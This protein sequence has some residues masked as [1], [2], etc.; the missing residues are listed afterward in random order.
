MPEPETFLIAKNLSKRFGATQVLRDVSLTIRAG[1]RVA[2]T[3]PSGAGKSTLLNCLGGIERPDSGEIRL[4]GVDLSAASPEEL[5]T[6]RRTRI[7][8][9][10]QFFHL[11]PTLTAAENIELPLQLAG[12]PEA[13]RRER[14]NSL[15]NRVGL[16]HR[17]E[18]HPAELS[19]GEQQ[20]V[21]I[22]RAVAHRPSLVLADEPTGALDSQHGEA[23]L[24]LLREMTVESGAT[25]ILVTHSREAAAICP[26][27][28]AM[29]DGQILTDHE[30]AVL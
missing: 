5:A 28:L 22:A 14:V 9:V 29:R 17:G 6:L 3:G 4:G 15:L 18:H 26:R 13:A 21:A 2:L 10:F 16:S 20:R 25:L 7:G 23:V 8:T 24:S 19:G 1:E 12:I 11:L 30:E 27:H